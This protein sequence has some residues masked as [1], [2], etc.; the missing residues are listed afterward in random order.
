MRLLS[1]PSLALKVLDMQMK[2]LPPLLLAA[3]VRKST[4]PPV[5]LIWRVPALSELTWP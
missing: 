3:P 1:V 2:A 5:P 4:W